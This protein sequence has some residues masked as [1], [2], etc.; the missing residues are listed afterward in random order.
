MQGSPRC[1]HVVYQQQVTTGHGG[2]AFQAKGVLHVLP[3]GQDGGLLG[4]AA[5]ESGSHQSA[6]YETYPR[7]VAQSLGYQVALIVAPMTPAVGDRK[8]TRLNSSH[9]N[10]SYA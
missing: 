2:G 9:A 8:S 6:F 10:I 5:V 4:L 7:G 3:S 1:H